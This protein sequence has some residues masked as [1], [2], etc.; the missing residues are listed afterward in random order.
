MP[1]KSNSKVFDNDYNAQPGMNDA[2]RNAD[3]VTWKVGVENL[4]G[5][6]MKDLGDMSGPQ[7]GPAY[8][9][10]AMGED[11]GKITYMSGKGK[12]PKV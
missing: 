1:V 8:D 9:S 6:V 3:S 12:S 4:T 5:G 2:Q 7:V 11:R 10:T